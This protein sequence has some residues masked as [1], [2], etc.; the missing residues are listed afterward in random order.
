MK[1]SSRSSRN[2][3]ESPHS[4]LVPAPTRRFRVLLAGFYHETHVFL[5][6]VTPWSDF[7]VRLSDDVFKR[8]GDGS[9]IDGILEEAE[10]SGLE[11]LPTID[12]RAGPSGVIADEA[13]ET[14]WN[15]FTRLA[16]PLLAA[17]VDA[18]LLVLHG[19]AQSQSFADA[20]GELLARIRALPGG[21]ASMIFGTLDLHANV[22]R[23]MC[24]HANALIA[25]RENPH[26][27]ARRMAVRTTEILAECL[28]RGCVPHVE[29][30]QP[31]L[32]WSP[33]STG[34]ATQ[35]LAGLQMMA[36]Q[37][38][39]ESPRLFACNIAAGFAFS[40]SPDAGV[41]MSTVSL[42]HTGTTLIN[43]QNLAMVAWATKSDAETR[44]RKVDE[45]LSNLR[46]RARRDRPVLF[47]ESAD[48]ISTGAPG[49]GT[50]L[51]RAFV[52]QRV[53]DAC[54]TINDPTAVATLDDVPIGGTRRLAIGGRGWR[55][56]PGPLVLAVT[57]VSRSDGRF[58]PTD[59]SSIVA[60][61][62]GA[63][64]RMG[65]CA[66]VRCGSVTILLTSRKMPPFD[67]AQLHSQG[68]TPSSFAAIGVKDS[69]AHQRA[70]GNIAAGYHLVD[71]PG[72]CSY[73]VARLKYHRLRRPVW[74]LDAVPEFAT[75]D[76]P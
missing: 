72:P 47:V 29:W 45:V 6:G 58:R 65:P 32:L 42:A 48:D 9:P 36:R 73:D 62:V 12:A 21:A 22:S 49:D 17:G 59:P 50:G 56:D 11:V 57:L 43:L 24:V 76:H 25:C 23:E 38:E 1:V 63:D 46:L 35:P 7:D 67:L 52:E 26:T 54:I 64:C 61:A 16:L 13:F 34:S 20:E 30:M 70:Y 69:V 18:I 60:L 14:F 33:C 31:Q 4:D 40:D 3:G 2:R 75:A 66:V 74:P 44:V 41:S 39:D 8:R 15:E 55:L 27:D 28:R 51:L 19:A 71:T 5:D 37:F 68:L 53:P 10:R